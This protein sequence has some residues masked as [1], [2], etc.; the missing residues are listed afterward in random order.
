MASPGRTC[1]SCRKKGVKGE[2]VKL[3]DTPAGVVIDYTEKLPGRGAYVCP[4]P[5]CIEGG[6]KEAA[7]SRAF[8][9]KI[10]PP[11]KGEF[12]DA[13]REKVT[14]KAVSLI[15]MARKSGLA[16]LGFDAAVEGY[17]RSG[18]GAVV[19][20]EDAAANT[21]RKFIEDASPAE[22][23]VYRFSTKDELGRMLGGAPVGVLYIGK[24][25]LSAALIRELG[26]LAIISRG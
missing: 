13:L 11:E 18:G 20:A 26:R 9:H 6:L 22:G 2:L 19:I 14:R 10:T 3:A 21:V 5:A 4:E 17:T 23:A 1:V 15:G 25:A 16:R 8:K 24:S 12:M 7:L